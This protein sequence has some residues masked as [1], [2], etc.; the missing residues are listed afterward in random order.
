MNLRTIGNIVTQLRREGPARTFGALC[1]RASE[2]YFEWRLGIRSSEIV[3]NEELGFTD[4]D[5][6]YYLATSFSGFRRLIRF[7]DHGA[8]RGTFVD[9]GAGMGR[10]VV[11]AA[12]RPYRRVVGVELSPELCEVAQANLARVRPRLRCADVSVLQSDATKFRIPD[13]MTVAFFQN[14]FH[15]DVLD[16]VV[17]NVA[18]SLEASPRLLH[19]VSNSPSLESAF[20]QQLRGYDWLVRRHAIALEHGRAGTIYTNARWLTP[21]AT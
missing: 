2:R 11:L 6:H 10:A 3:S 14:P 5:C 1:H 4:P 7:V 19:V 15:G 8:E 21:A 16:R 18:R 13:D 17:E 12:M 20:E 9:F